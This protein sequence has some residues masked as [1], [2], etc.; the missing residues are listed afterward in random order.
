VPEMAVVASMGTV[1]RGSWFEGW[2]FS[3]E[4]TDSPSVPA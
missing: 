4:S 1:G 2:A 3:H